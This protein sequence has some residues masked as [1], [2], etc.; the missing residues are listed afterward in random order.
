MAFTSLGGERASGAL[1]KKKPILGLR[2]DFRGSGPYGPAEKGTRHLRDH[3]R[4]VFGP[5]R[6]TESRVKKH[7][8]YLGLGVEQV[9]M[10]Q[11]RHRPCL[12][13]GLR[14]GRYG[15]MCWEQQVLGSQLL[16]RTGYWC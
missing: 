9:L 2:L 6:I 13:E 8:P 4:T 1:N 16:D 3:S 11:V 15:N 5:P 7:L 12:P 10:E 14:G